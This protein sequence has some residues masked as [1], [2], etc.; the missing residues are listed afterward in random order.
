MPSFRIVSHSLTAPKEASRAFLDPIPVDFHRRTDGQRA[1]EDHLQDK[2]P[3]A[4][5]D[6]SVRCAGRANKG[7]EARKDPEPHGLN[8]LCRVISCSIFDSVMN[9]HKRG[10]IER[11]GQL[12]WL[13]RP[14]AMARA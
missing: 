12:F 11:C 2:T 9:E 3:R 4:G 14:L 13:A 10:K 5:I 1:R 8:L 7:N 6:I